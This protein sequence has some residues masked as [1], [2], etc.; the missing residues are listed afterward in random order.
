EIIP[1]L[2]IEGGEITEDQVKYAFHEIE[3][4]EVRKFILNEGVRTDG[5]KY[6][7]I[8]AVTCEIGVLPRT[9]GSALFTRGQTQ[10]LGVATLGTTRDEQRLDSIEGDIFKN[11]MLHY[12]FPPFSV[13][14]IKPMRGPGR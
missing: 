13:G 11:F 1:R 7:E 12:N 6:D 3:K 8:R 10:S 4:E 9:H 14:E 2:V 5:R